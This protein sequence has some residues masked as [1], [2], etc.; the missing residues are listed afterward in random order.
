VSKDFA[1]QQEDYKMQGERGMFCAQTAIKDKSTNLI[2]IL[3][4]D[5][6]AFFA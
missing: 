3:A 4:A 2:T 6:A 1:T 5:F